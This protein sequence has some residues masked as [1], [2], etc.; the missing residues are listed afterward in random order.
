MNLVGKRIRVKESVNM[1]GRY[2]ID[3][4]AF[5]NKKG[6]IVECDED[7]TDFP[8]DIVFD[9]EIL[10][11]FNQIKNEGLLWR[12]EDVEIIEDEFTLDDIEAGMVVEL[13]NEIVYVACYNKEE[14]YF[15]NKNSFMDKVSY[16]SNM[17]IDKNKK[18]S[19]DIIRVYDLA[20]AGQMCCAINLC[21]IKDL[22]K[23]LDSLSLKVVWEENP[24]PKIIEKYDLANVYAELK[25]DGTITIKNKTN[26]SHIAKQ[27]NMKYAISANKT[28]IF[29]C[30]KGDFKCLIMAL[31]KDL[32]VKLCAGVRRHSNDGISYCIIP[33][34]MECNIGS[35]VEADFGQG[36]CLAQV[37]AI[38]SKNGAINNKII[39]VL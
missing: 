6:K 1:K 21:N 9:D 32:E 12:M 35:V 25:D 30:Y 7:Y 19:W 39:R 4:S 37:V 11:N 8:L 18:D 36:N 22:K 31:N 26:K 2:Y 27:N 34:G 29:K 38:E 33:K 24:Q 23:R 5:A 17:K 15:I 20:F 28:E 10:Q 16:K 14:L 3:R 13:R